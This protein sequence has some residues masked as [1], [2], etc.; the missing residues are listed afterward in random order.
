MVILGKARTPSG[1]YSKIFT[2]RIE[3]SVKKKNPK[4]GLL[5]T[6]LKNVYSGQSLNNLR[7]MT[8]AFYFSNYIPKSN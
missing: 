4:V 6:S 2:E 5:K 3:F 8:K 1:L 7:K